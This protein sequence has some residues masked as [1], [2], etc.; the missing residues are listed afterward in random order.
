MP[1][2][3]DISSEKIQGVKKHTESTNLFG[4]ITSPVEHTSSIDN[5]N[6]EYEIVLAKGAV[7][8]G[9]LVNT[10]KEF[11]PSIYVKVLGY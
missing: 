2:N 4:E 7:E 9:D 10:D 8:T 3:D 11:K 6:Q 5:S 1:L